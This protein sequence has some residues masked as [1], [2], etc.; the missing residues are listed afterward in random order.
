MQIDEARLAEMRVV[1]ALRGDE[2]AFIGA[3][4]KCG[5]NDAYTITDVWRAANGDVPPVPMPPF[6]LE[7]TGKDS[8]LYH[9]VP[10]FAAQVRELLNGDV[11]TSSRQ[12]A[13]TMPAKGSRV[14]QSTSSRRLI[15]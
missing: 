6:C 13:P 4:K 8:G 12:H 5:G 1:H 2:W 7:K 10:A 15:K 9:L 11:A 3:C 14:T